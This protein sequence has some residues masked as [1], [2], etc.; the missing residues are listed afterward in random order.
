MTYRRLLAL[1]L[2]V[3]G[4][5]GSGPADGGAP[6]ADAGTRD[7]GGAARDAGGPIDAGVFVP[8]DPSSGCAG[9]LE[10]VAPSGTVETV[11]DGTAAS[12][13]ED[14]LHAAVG[15]LSGEAGGTLAFDC[16]GEHTITLTRSVYVDTSITIDGG[17][18]ITL[19]GGGRVRVI[20]LDHYLDFTLQRIIIR[21]GYVD[22]GLENESGAGLLSPWFGTLRIIDCAFENNVSAS[23]D[24]DVGG[25][26]IYAGGLT[27]AVISGSRFVGNRG[28]TGGA[29]LSRS[30]N[31][32]VVDT[33]FVEN[34]ATSYA[35]SGQYGNGGGLY[36][37]RMWLDAPVDFVICGAV[38]DG[39]HAT[40]H[41]SAFFSYN[42]EGSGALFD[43]CTFTDN[44]MDG[45]PG[46]G[47]GTV[48]HE[49][50]PLTLVS[51]TFSNN[52]TG[53]HASGLFLGGGTDAEVVSCTFDGNVTPGN[54]GALWAGNGTVRATHVTFA[55]NAADYAP[56][57]FRGS[58]GAVTLTDCVFS[59]NRT[60]N[61]FSA[62]ACH[63]T[64]GDGGGNV[65][66]P[67]TKNN[68]RGD[69]PCAEGV[70]FADPE[71]APLADNGGPT[72]TM[73]LSEA[74]PALDHA[75]S[76]EGFDQ[77]GTPRSVPCDSGAYERE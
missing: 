4:C 47:T 51:S 59:N 65:Q 41:G 14:A 56:A 44:D 55:N 9:R 15:A 38:F 13:T 71:L 53:A 69:M 17:G 11:G 12:C 40:Q 72:W 29:I 27:E 32:R 77:R 75:T 3:L 66:W 52:R 68:G 46:G 30:T 63:E 48:Y 16:G 50:V 60:D 20:E 54:A 45:S 62:V 43:R 34:A 19:S 73:A 61:E 57:I 49:G 6:P 76:C 21:D 26:A 8:P 7:G 22:A 1:A 36:I 64:F 18:A 24:H 42:L 5:D 35:E 67:D 28:S 25:G 33:S 74:S 31:L 39:N 23:Q 10:A 37:D 70:L 58:S 2:L